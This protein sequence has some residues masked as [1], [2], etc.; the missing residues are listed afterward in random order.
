MSLHNVD[1]SHRYVN[2][3]KESHYEVVDIHE[4]MDIIACNS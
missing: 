1:N 4:E 3:Y 2:V